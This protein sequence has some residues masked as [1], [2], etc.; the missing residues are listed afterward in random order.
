MTE[1][2]IL[3]DS[4]YPVSIFS[5]IHSSSKKKFTSIND[6]T[7]TAMQ[8]GAFLFGKAI[9]VIDRGYD[10]NKI[11]LKPDELERDYVVRLTAKRKLFFHGKW[12]SDPKIQ[13]HFSDTAA[14]FLCMAGKSAAEPD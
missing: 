13:Y 7:F 1:A 8:C 6:V 3:T 11:F 9:F 12:V 14:D 5:R 4:N 2:G 10:D